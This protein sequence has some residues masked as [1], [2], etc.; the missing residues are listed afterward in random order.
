MKP[1]LYRTILVPV[2]G[3]EDD[4]VILDHVVPLARFH[5]AQLL[6]V[7]VADGWAA[8]YYRE[9]ADSPEV[10][11]DRQYLQR[12]AVSL[13]A[14]GLDVQ[15]VL[16]FGDPGEEIVKLAQERNCDLIAMTT[17]G[18]RFISDLLYGSA[19]SKVRH[20]VDIPVL[21]LRRPILAAN[22][23]GSR[24]PKNRHSET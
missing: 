12:L 13:R 15:T 16:G 23:T 4:T 22:G 24:K 17:H 7:H 21:L 2:E 6:L 20:A 3:T 11:A 8:R 19:A 14:K 5:D 9:E 1:A 18:H 10:R